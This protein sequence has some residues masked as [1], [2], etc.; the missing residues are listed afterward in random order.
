MRSNSSIDCA[1]HA[2]S[3]GP[4]HRIPNRTGRGAVIT[5]RPLGHSRERRSRGLFSLFRRS[6]PRWFRCRPVQR[7]GLILG[8]PSDRDHHRDP[9]AGRIEPS[10]VEVSGRSGAG[11]PAE[12][13]ETAVLTSEVGAQS[14]NGV[15][16]KWHRN[17]SDY[18]SAVALSLRPADRTLRHRGVP[19]DGRLV[20]LDA[21]GSA[22]GSVSRAADRNLSPASP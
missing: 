12:G 5:S 9:P 7:R 13:H 4:S 21:P 1:C 18:R 11:A 2:R 14:W 19:H 15:P 20:L 10:A 22:R 17:P 16:V 3:V 6:Q 8:D